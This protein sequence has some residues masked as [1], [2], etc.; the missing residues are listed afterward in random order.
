M[1][2]IV[3]T[4]LFHRD[5]N[6]IAIR[7]TKDWELI[8]LVKLLPAVAFSKT[9]SCW[10]V[11]AELVK[12]NDIFNLFKGKAWVDYTALRQ[13]KTSADI[14][15]KNTQTTIHTLNIHQA[16]CLNALS[17]KLS[18]KGYSPSTKKTYLSQFKSFLQF[19]QDTHPADLG[20]QEIKDYILNVIEK[21]SL[22]RST[23]NQAINAI[24]FYFEKVLHQERKI[25][26]LERPLKEKRLPQVLN[27]E[28]VL[29]IFNQIT[30]L[31]HKV[32]LMLIYAAGLRRSELLNLRTGD[33]DMHRCA[34]FIR[35]GKGKKDRQSILS[36]TLLPYLTDYLL[37]YH[38][39]FWLFEGSPG[40]PYSA[41]SLQKILGK[42]V[43][44]AGI[45]KDVKLHSLR[46]SFATHML[47][48][49][50]STRYI[51][52]LLGHESSKTTEIYTH[53]ANFG[54]DRITSPLDTI[55]TAPEQTTVSDTKK[56]YGR[57]GESS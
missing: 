3:L 47:E 50:V 14:P 17:E 35:G 40:V 28:E 39:S 5:T 2:K 12:I 34:V 20:E 42:A 55:M 27:Q 31:K 45:R 54:I 25:Y 19:H 44:K 38:P 16:N 13:T 9:H 30:N 23:Q 29:S 8:S 49:G 48:S 15:G 56:I 24:K 4:P 57:N 1:K 37:R 7:F 53:V 41:S 46:H 33:I 6:C 43:A 11:P 21:R 26:S 52:V 10:Y 18:I 36:K 32:M 51:Q 22:S